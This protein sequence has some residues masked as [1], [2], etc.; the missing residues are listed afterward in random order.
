MTNRDSGGQELAHYEISFGDFIIFGGMGGI[1]YQ[2]CTHTSIERVNYC[3]SQVDVKYFSL[4]TKTNEIK[5]LRL[6]FP[7]HFYVMSAWR[8]HEL[9]VALCRVF[10]KEVICEELESR[11]EAD[12]SLHNVMSAWR[13]HELCVALCR[14]FLKEVTYVFQPL[15]STAAGT[16]ASWQRVSGNTSQ[17]AH[18]GNSER[19]TITGLYCPPPFSISPPYDGFAVFA[20]PNCIKRLYVAG[21]RRRSRKAGRDPKRPPQ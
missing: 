9:C 16:N 2:V 1:Q 8:C 4:W 20:Y 19:C 3:C 10:L 17:K 11:L 6:C 14:V 21:I 15:G 7:H 5:A 13:C 18:S 12:V